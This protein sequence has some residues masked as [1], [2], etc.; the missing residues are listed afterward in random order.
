MFWVSWWGNVNGPPTWASCSLQDVVV[1]LMSSLCV[2]PLQVWTLFLCTLVMKCLHSTFPSA[3]RWQTASLTPNTWP[4]TFWPPRFGFSSLTYCSER[5]SSGRFRRR[6]HPRMPEDL[7][8]A[9]AAGGKAEHF[10]GCS[11][12]YQ[13]SCNAPEAIHFEFLKTFF[14]IYSELAPV[15]NSDFQ[16]KNVSID[17]LQSSELW[18]YFN[19]STKKSSTNSKVLIEITD[20]FHLSLLLWIEFL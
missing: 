5:K 2:I 14:W 4:R 19:C 6:R 18:Y 17:Q 9:V 1:F 11:H 7:V 10:E 20:V 3:G 15:Q 12:G 13:N 16:R 8:S